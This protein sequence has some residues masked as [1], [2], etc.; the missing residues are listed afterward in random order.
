MIFLLYFSLFLIIFFTILVVF[1][2]YKFY[3]NDSRLYLWLSVMLILGFGLPLFTEFLIIDS[4]I[5][6]M[7]TYFK[8]NFQSWILLNLSSSI[9]ITFI[10]NEISSNSKKYFFISIFT[11]IFFIGIS[12]PIYAIKPR[13][14]DRFNNDFHGLDGTKY[15]QNAEYSQEGNWID[16]SDSYQAIDWINKIYQQIGL[17]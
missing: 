6:R 9:I 10:L 16:L 2:K 17:F 11:L 8:F 1:L 7:N 12:Y 15:M 4:D 14:M 13:V 3:E 5:N